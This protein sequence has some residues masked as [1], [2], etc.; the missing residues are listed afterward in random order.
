MEVKVDKYSELNLMS[1]SIIPTPQSIKAEQ[2][3]LTVTQETSKSPFEFIESPKKLPE[4]KAKQTPQFKNQLV[5][6]LH[7]A[8]CIGQ[9]GRIGLQVSGRFLREINKL[10]IDLTIA[11]YTNS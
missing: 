2:S 7:S 4:V 11:N 3:N 9:S 1:L 5:E 8:N 6:I 10:S